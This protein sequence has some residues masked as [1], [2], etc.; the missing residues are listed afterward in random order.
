MVIDWRCFRA[1][2]R[3]RGYAKNRELLNRE[4]K[5]EFKPRWKIRKEETFCRLHRH[6]L[7]AKA[8]AQQR[9]TME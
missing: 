1:D 9:L 7:F 6:A 8:Y 5:K 3:A 2:Y 4:K